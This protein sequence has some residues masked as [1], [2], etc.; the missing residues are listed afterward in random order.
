MLS[1]YLL[2]P[3]SN[4]AL[5]FP[6][7]KTGVMIFSKDIDYEREGFKRLKILEKD[8]VDYKKLKD[9]GG[10]TPKTGN[11]PS[12]YIP[13]YKC[14]LGHGIVESTDGWVPRTPDYICNDFIKK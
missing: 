11:K 9:I 6:I 8:Q 7:E 3:N 12:D 1:S 4:V 5:N 13:Q 14:K 2:V 10:N